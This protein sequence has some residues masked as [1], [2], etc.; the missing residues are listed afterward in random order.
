MSMDDDNSGM[1][2]DS[3]LVAEY[4]LGLLDEDTRRQVAARIAADPAL[5]REAHEWRRRLSM[6]D[7]EF[8]EIAPPA[9]T[10]AAIERRLFDAEDATGRTSFWDSLALW[11]GLAFGGVAAAV[12][13]VGFN[14]L[15][16]PALTPEV[17]ATRLVA[18]IESE[19]SSIR[20]VA[21]YDYASGQVRLTGLSGEVPT[22]RDLELWFI[23]GENAP[24][25]MG[26]IPVNAHSV[27]EVA[28]EINEQFRAGTTLAIT[29][30]PKGGSPT[31]VATGPLVAA[32]ETVPI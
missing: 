18:A 1:N 32:G 29:L 13:A 5:A 3:A 16:P 6:L 28:P 4:V 24:V 19:G 30:E 25:S 20:F 2:G 7:S 8:A 27:V 21:L 26:V 17:F 11:R 10:F 12:L 23:E 31:G 14:L 22:D 15:Q 9:S